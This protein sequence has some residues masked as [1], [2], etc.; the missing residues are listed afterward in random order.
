MANARQRG[1]TLIETVVAIAMMTT[2]IISAMGLA[3]YSFQSAD[4][5]SKQVIGT[6]LAREGIEGVKN[7]RDSNWLSVSG[8]PL[9]DCSAYLGAGAKCHANWLTS[10]IA[11]AAGSYAMDFLSYGASP[12]YGPEL[13]NTGSLPAGN[14]YK[15][16]YHA[17]T[18]QYTV[19]R[20]SGPDP[21]SIFSRK[22]TLNVYTSNPPAYMSGLGAGIYSVQDPL[23]EVVSTVW[24]NSRKCPITIDPT[25]LP[26]GCKVTLYMHLTNW[27]NF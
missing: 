7:M 17:A 9:V 15:L 24:W 16:F 2:G 3:V 12:T 13:V 26:S 8:D 19:N 18:G 1:Q 6:E 22:V 27:R 25:T 4:D 21:L 10:P 20:V 14:G 11:L 23:V 5:S